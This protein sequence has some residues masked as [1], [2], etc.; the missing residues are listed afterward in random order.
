ML[1]VIGCLVRD[2]DIVGVAFDNSGSSNF[3]KS[4]FLKFAD[5]L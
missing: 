4:G 2:G 3:N 5:I 1:A